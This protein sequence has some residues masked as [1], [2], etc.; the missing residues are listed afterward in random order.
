M[1]IS[2]GCIVFNLL[3]TLPKDMF[4]KCIESVHDFAHEII[5]V[6]GASNGSDGNTKVF[7]KDGHSTDG[8][9]EYLYSLQSEFDKITIIPSKGFWNGKTEMCNE[10]A[11]IA[12]GDYIWQLDADEFYH[13]N[14]IV[15]II[16]ILETLKPDAVHFYAN[17]FF[18]GY[19]YCIGETGKN[20]A[21]FLPWM[22]IFRH[23]PNK[24][25]WLSHEPPN[26]QCDDLICNQGRVITRD[27]TL[28]LGIKMFH[29][30][31]VCKEQID[32]KERFYGNNQ[33]T[34]FWNMFQL[35]QGI[36]IFGDRSYK[37]TGNH[38]V[39]FSEEIND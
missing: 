23:I 17:H 30:T 14:D 26:Y 21:N 6:E 7:T 10:Y 34:R 33:Y 20:W 37:F 16:D 38:P 1:K 2:F 9:L 35:D 28:N 39:K 24:S 29:Y 27:Q 19:D 31:C 3:D 25:K 18:G 32:F 4:R 12:T 15:K 36:K 13:K 5:I 8:T 11:K 22:R